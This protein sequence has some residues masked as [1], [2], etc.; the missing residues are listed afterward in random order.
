MK[1]SKNKIGYTFSIEGKKIDL[2]K[3]TL[4]ERE[5]IALK[6]NDIAMK[7]IGYRRKQSKRP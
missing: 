2:E 1:K 4:E 6:Y 5:N 3:M 7:S